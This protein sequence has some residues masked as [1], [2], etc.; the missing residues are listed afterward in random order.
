MSLSFSGL[1][2]DAAT[3]RRRSRPRLRFLLRQQFQNKVRGSIT[4]AGRVCDR[5]RRTLSPLAHNHFLNLDPTRLE[6]KEMIARKIK[7]N[8]REAVCASG[9]SR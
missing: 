8:H 2:R 4:G 7:S 5:S 6:I 1:G 3:V 9:L